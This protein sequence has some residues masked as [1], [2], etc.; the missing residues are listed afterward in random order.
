MK[1]WRKSWPGSPSFDALDADVRGVFRE[2]ELHADDEGRIALGT[3]EPYELLKRLLCRS[4]RD[5]Q[6]LKFWL[7]EW[8]K[9]GCLVLEADALYLPRFAVQQA[10][11]NRRQL[12]KKLLELREERAQLGSG[13]DAVG[14]ESGSGTAPVGTQLGAGSVGV[15]SGLGIGSPQNPSESFNTGC[16]IEREKE[17]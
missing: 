7:G 10:A 11:K 12:E 13:S 17:R 15:R 1:D 9:D 6:K 2:L 4:K 14:E 16:Q 5:R 3:M 8:L